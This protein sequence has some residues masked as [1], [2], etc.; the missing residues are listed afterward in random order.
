MEGIEY[1]E[2]LENQQDISPN[3]YIEK[4]K[5]E[6]SFLWKCQIMIVWHMQN[7]EDKCIVDFIL[8]HIMI[9]AIK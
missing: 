5:K 4:G 3:F 7:Y 6:N 2:G 8:F 9:F 1:Y